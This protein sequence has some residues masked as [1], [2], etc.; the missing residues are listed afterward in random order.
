VAVALALLVHGGLILLAERSD[1]I[2]DP[3]FGDKLAKLEARIESRPQPARTMILLGSSRTLLGFRGER[4]E[5]LLRDEFAE[6]HPVAFNFGIPASGPITHRVYLQRLLKAGIRPDFLIV[7]ILPPALQDGPG[8]PVEA[9]FFTG[10]RLASAELELVQ[11]HGYDPH[12]TREQWRENWQNPLFALRHKLLAR[13]VPSWVPPAARADWS[14]GTDASGWT[15]PPR[16]TITPE[17]RAEREAKIRTDFASALAELEPERRPFAALREIVSICQEQQ[18]PLQLLLMPEDAKFRALY[19]PQVQQKL[20][21]SMQHLADSTGTPLIDAR[22]WLADDEFYDG[23][24]MFTVG[25]NTFTDRLTRE[26]LL[27]HFRQRLSPRGPR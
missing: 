16:Q 14:R 1:R 25:A 5:Q 13:V 9:A 12:F 7:E 22:L 26:V 18:I 15:T 6:E 20:L 2:R 8:G 11:R 23:H 10:D 19:P 4:A 27:P 17:D 3:A 24:H 21:H